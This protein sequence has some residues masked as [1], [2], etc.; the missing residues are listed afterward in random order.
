MQDEIRSIISLLTSKQNF[1]YFLQ[2]ENE[3]AGFIPEKLCVPSNSNILTL[4][5]DSFFIFY[6]PLFE[7]RFKDISIN[8]SIYLISPTKNVFAK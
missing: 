7:N 3:T 5:I 4:I 2:F 6:S 8:C 1:I